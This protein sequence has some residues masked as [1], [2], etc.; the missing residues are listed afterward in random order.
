MFDNIKKKIEQ[1]AQKKLEEAGLLSSSE[2][3]SSSKPEIPETTEKY[4]TSPPKSLGFYPNGIQ[5]SMTNALSSSRSTNNW[6][7][8]LGFKEGLQ[9][10]PERA[11]R[12][13]F[14]VMLIY[15]EAGEKVDLKEIARLDAYF[16]GYD[17][18]TAEWENRETKKLE[19]LEQEKKQAAKK[20]ESK[21]FL[22]KVLISGGTLAI[23]HP[24][25]KNKEGETNWPVVILD[26]SVLGFT[27]LPSFFGEED[28]DI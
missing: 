27:W 1:E 5:K 18:G 15:Q 26:L 14:F 11:S 6:Y 2:D 16:Q 17:D 4:R 22:G 19:K 23:T 25:M 10:I 28:Q 20:R 13:G 12:D 24:I 21:S 8:K 3:T 9:G 7:Y